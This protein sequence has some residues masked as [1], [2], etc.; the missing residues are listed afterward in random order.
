MRT[1][2]SAVLLHVLSPQMLR[3]EVFS[4]GLS[5]G[6]VVD[7]HAHLVG[8]NDSGSF[9]HPSTK[10]WWSPLQ[11][12]K[13]AILMSAAQA[14]LHKYYYSCIPPFHCCDC[15][16]CACNYAIVLYSQGLAICTRQVFSVYV[17]GVSG[18]GYCNLL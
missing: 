7:Y 18:F 1:V 12:L 8:H 6:D 9:L 4:D 3:D 16:M 2:Y 17:E 11:R 13:G 15:A 10:T 14:R 5:P